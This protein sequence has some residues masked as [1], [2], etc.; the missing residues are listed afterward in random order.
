MR[1]AT[2]VI[3]A[4]TVLSLAASLLTVAPVADG[5]T[6]K[7]PATQVAGRGVQHDRVGPGHRPTAAQ[8]QQ[9]EQ[10]KAGASGAGRVAGSTAS[11][12]PMLAPISSSGPLTRV[13]TSQT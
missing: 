11:L 8:L 3:Q 10:Q 12:A 4:V 13:E 5:L 6:A 7:P 1:R 2:R 9:H